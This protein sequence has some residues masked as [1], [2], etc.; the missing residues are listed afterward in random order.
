MYKLKH[1]NII[2]QYIKHIYI[3]KHCTRMIMS[4][5]YNTERQMFDISYRTGENLL[6]PVM[7]SARMR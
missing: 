1:T 5:I 6:N 2:K 7:D 4:Y 3:Y